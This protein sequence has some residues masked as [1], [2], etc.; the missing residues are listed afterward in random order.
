MASATTAQISGDLDFALNDFPVTLTTVLPTT[1]VGVTFSASRQNV[2][3]AFVVEENGRET[4]I[5]ARFH[6]NINGVST[7]PLKG[8]VLNDGTDVFK[9]QT[10]TTDAAG[11]A[12]AL[13]VSARYSPN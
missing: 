8:W 10:V 6:I 12:L 4:Q 5:A 1:S 2:L 3:N 9:V 11:V 7:Y 13:D